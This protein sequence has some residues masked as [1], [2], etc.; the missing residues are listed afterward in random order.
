MG[1]YSVDQ[2]SPQMTIRSS[3]DT[4]KLT[5]FAFMDSHHLQHLDVKG[6]RAA[7]API[8]VLP[9]PN[10]RRVRQRQAPDRDA[11]KEQPRIGESKQD[12]LL[13]SSNFSQI[14]LDE[15]MK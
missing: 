15:A 2:L 13:K 1:M 4:A 6:L 10:D 14:F 11:C 7:N 12:T 9:D 5:H 3:Y 8:S